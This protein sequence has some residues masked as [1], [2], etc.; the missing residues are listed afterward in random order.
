MFASILFPV[1]APPLSFDEN[2][3]EAQTWD[4]G[5]AKIV[6]CTQPRSGDLLDDGTNPTITPVQ[7][8]GIQ[9]GWDD[10][11]LVIWFN[12]QADADPLVEQRDSPLGIHG[13]RVDVALHRQTCASK[14]C[15]D[16]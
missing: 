1:P 2:I 12:R 6:H 11:Q 4:D 3:V 14:N 8:A 7:D 15:D 10:E 5:F 16:R 9:L 13:Y